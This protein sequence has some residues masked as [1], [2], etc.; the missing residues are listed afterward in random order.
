[1][2]MCCYSITNMYVITLL[3]FLRFKSYPKNGN[4]TDEYGLVDGRY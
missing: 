4:E 2:C 1:M 3:S